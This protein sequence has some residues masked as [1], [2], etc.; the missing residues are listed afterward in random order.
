MVTWASKLMLSTHALAIGLKEHGLIDERQFETIR[1]VR[2]PRENKADPELPTSL[3]PSTRAAKV[4]AM[5][6][7]LSDYYVGLA[8]DAHKK[9][10]ISRGRLCEILLTDERELKTFRHDFEY[11]PS[12]E[13]SLF[14]R[15]NCRIF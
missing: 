1:S 2:V 6:E 5:E 15:S 10:I 4:R 3:S 14:M 13:I 7:G 11:V 9:G 8:L 12:K